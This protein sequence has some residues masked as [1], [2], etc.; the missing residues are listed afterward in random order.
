MAQ[1]PE[2]KWTV[3][4][5]PSALFCGHRLVRRALKRFK[6]NCGRIALLGFH[7]PIPQSADLA[8]AEACRYSENRQYILAPSASF[9]GT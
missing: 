8:G 6:E 7:F 2:E 5:A 9:C 1:E 3:H 4:Y